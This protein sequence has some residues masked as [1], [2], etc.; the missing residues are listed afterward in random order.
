MKIALVSPYDFASPGGVVS[1]ISC[2]EQQFTRMGHDVKIIAPASA[3]IYTVGDRFIRIGTPRPLPVSGSVARITISLR[4][5]GQ[6]E[7][8][9]E[10]EKFDICHLHEPLMP[11]LCTT[12]LRQ[13]KCP[14]VGTFHASGGKPWYTMFSPI[15]KWYLDRWIRK[16]DGRITVSQVA[17]RYVNTYFPAEYKIIPNGVDT[18]HFNKD[19]KPIDKFMD[20]KIN[21]LFV[22]RLEKRKGFTH[23]LEAYR[24]IK[25][26]VPNCR[27][28]QVGPG[29]RYRKRYEKRA[30]K[31]GLTDVHFT[32]YASYKDLPRY[33]K[34]ADV[35][36][37]PATGRE[38]QGIVLMEA[39]SVGRP[40]IAT[41]IEGYN[42]VLTDGVEGIAVP[43]KDE[44]KL[45]E[46]ILKLI[47]DK[48]LREQMGERGILRAKQYDWTLIAKQLLDFYKETLENVKKSPAAP[49]K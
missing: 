41:N 48:P 38:S 49:A 40:I 43:P 1:H 22:G 45:A 5:Y 10:R 13:K 11:N 14:M 3:A 34:T 27:L 20:G 42:S 21:I 44:Q 16:L 4:L 15:V 36:C 29:A 25:P 46:A 12:I 23:L 32:G 17:L 35:V 26:Q 9:F 28:I 8:V 47:N 19:V 37:F 39:M 31:Y 33:Y 7:R 6:V 18:Q 30:R 2:L 24:M